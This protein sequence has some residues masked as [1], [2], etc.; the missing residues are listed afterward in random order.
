MLDNFDAN[1]MKI[2]AEKLKKEHPHI[3]LEGSGGITDATIA[4]YFCPC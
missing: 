3:L 2:V 4:D 1:G